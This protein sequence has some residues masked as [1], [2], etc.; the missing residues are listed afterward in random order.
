MISRVCQ[1]P[2]ETHA[3]ITSC[4]TFRK[5]IVSVNLRAVTALA[6]HRRCFIRLILAG[7]I[8]DGGVRCIRRASAF[9]RLRVSRY[10]GQFF[11]VLLRAFTMQREKRGFYT[12]VFVAMYVATFREQHI[13]VYLR[14]FICC[15][16]MQTE[17]DFKL[18]TV[19][20]QV[21]F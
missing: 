4:F 21:T 19:K 7:K 2:F 16:K 14:I 9:R 1:W 13:F 10:V 11:S 3:F 15:I 8:V 20:K 5:N 18:N 17:A 12:Y 6:C